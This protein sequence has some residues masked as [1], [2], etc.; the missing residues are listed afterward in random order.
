MEF[1]GSDSLIPSCSYSDQCQD[2]DRLYPLHDIRNLLAKS[3]C[4]ST[5]LSAAIPVFGTSI[6]KQRRQNL[7]KASDFD[8]SWS[9]NYEGKIS[10]LN[11]AE[12]NDIFDTGLGLKGKGMDGLEEDMFL[13]SSTEGSPGAGEA[14]DNVRPP[15][16]HEDSTSLYADALSRNTSYVSGLQNQSRE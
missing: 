13:F 5:S 8:D 12:N 7:R 6:S 14:D 16:E 3:L 10:F 15:L 2:V 4:L 1:V 9:R 11:E